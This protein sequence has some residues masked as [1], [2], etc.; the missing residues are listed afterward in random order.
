MVINCQNYDGL[1]TDRLLSVGKDDFCGRG[2]RARPKHREIPH[3]PCFVKYAARPPNWPSSS[4]V[5]TKRPYLPPTTLKSV[6]WPALF[7]IVYG[8]SVH[9]E[10]DE[11]VSLLTRHGDARENSDRML[12][13]D[14]TVT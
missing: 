1:P 2:A 8:I 13:T 4:L 7:T 5:Q 6:N 11:Y 14:Q 12:T 10:C 9:F 3:P